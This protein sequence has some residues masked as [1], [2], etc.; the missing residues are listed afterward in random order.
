M[1]G[2]GFTPLFP[3]RFRAVE[4]IE[5]DLFL[6]PVKNSSRGVLPEQPAF[7][8]VTLCHVLRRRAKPEVA[9]QAC[10][11]VAFPEIRSGVNDDAGLVMTLDNFDKPIGYATDL[12]RR[13][14]QRAGW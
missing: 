5:V 1:H 10:H 8:A 7:N 12:G 2:A 3:L 14:A 11:T 9:F 4:A 6:D 13:R